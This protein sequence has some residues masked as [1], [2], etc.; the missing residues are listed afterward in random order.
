MHGLLMGL[1][2]IGGHDSRD[3]DVMRPGPRRLAQRAPNS[4]ALIEPSGAL[5]LRSYWVHVGVTA[6]HSRTPHQGGDTRRK[7]RVCTHSR[8]RDNHSREREGHI[9][10]GGDS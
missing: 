2:E 3:S 10:I 4:S 8:E 5:R 1:S 6:T 9:R 7:D